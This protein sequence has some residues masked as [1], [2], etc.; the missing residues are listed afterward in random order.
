MMDD[1]PPPRIDDPA[2]LMRA[3]NAGDTGAYRR[4]LQAL[5]PLIRGHVRRGLARCG[6]GQD[7]GE[8]IVQ[9]TLLAVHLKRH[10]WDESLPLEPWVRAIAT[11]KLIDHVRR[12][13]RMI[14]VDLDDVAEVVADDTIPAP[15]RDID[16][17]QVIAS[18][19][20]RDRHIVQ[21]MAV[22]GRSAREVAS[23]LDMTEGAV[24]V[25]LHRALKA[26]AERLRRT[27]P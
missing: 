5:V 12:T 2:S 27:T 18:L 14:P 10:T 11:Y 7:D 17:R 13:G 4:V 3:A 1:E 8:D 15:D 22:E 19:P 16:R 6:R 25:A 9:E 23:D 20:Q 24:R 26:L 21:A